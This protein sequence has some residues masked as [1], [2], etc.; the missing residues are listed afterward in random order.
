MGTARSGEA[1]A[2]G[3]QDQRVAAKTESLAVNLAGLVRGI[4]LVTFPAASTIFTS[5][6][7]YGLPSSQYGDMFLAHVVTAIAA[8]LLGAELAWRSRVDVMY[9]RPA[10]SRLWPPSRGSAWWR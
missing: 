9:E 6:S 10:A 8:A 3:G 4:V 2:G 5:K 7:D 1:A